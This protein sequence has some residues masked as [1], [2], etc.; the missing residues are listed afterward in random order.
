MNK[1]QVQLTLVGMRGFDSRISG[2]QTQTTMQ[3]LPQ[4]HI[5][6]VEPLSTDTHFDTLPSSPLTVGG[7]L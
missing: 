1:H 3:N 2:L 5:A 7:G 6:I 4:T